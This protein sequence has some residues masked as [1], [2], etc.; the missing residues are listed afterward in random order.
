MAK[1]GRPTKSVIRQN[2][3]EILYFMGEGY[4]YQIYK[5]YKELFAPVTLRVIY[6]HLAKGK[7]IGEFEVA[8]VKKMTGDYSWG[9]EAERIFYKLGPNAKPKILP[10]V[11]AFFEKQ[12]G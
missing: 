10:E 6:Y 1:R 12:Q 5:A 8:G 7:S 11:K 9:P 2:V 3:V 4:G